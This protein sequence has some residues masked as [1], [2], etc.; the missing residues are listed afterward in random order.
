MAV[1]G[2][3]SCEYGLIRGMQGDVQ[4]REDERKDIKIGKMK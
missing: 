2:G 3:I 1:E 4:T